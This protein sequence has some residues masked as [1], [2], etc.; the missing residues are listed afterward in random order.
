MI[1]LEVDGRPVEVPENSTVMDAANR[2]GIY[3]PHFCYHRKLSIAANC[4]MCLVQVEKAP[5]PLPACATPVTEGMKVWTHSEL[6]VQA[7]KGV[8]ELLLI[9]HPLDCPICDQGGECQLQDLAVGYGPSASR[10]REP[11]RVVANKELGPLVSA[12]EMT[13]CIHCTR[14]VRFGQEIA[15]IMELG[16]A[17]RGEHAEIMAFVGR[18]VDSELSGNMIDVCPVGAL[19]SRPFRYSARTWELAR[20]R[21]VAPHDSLGSNLVVQVMQDRVM[22]VLPLENEALNECWLSDRDRFSY[23]GLNSPQRLGAPMIKREGAWQE[24]DWPT[25]LEH[26]ATEL[27]RLRDTHGGESI[28]ALATPQST[29]EELYLLGRLTRGLGSGNVDFRLRQLDFSAD[30]TLTGTPWLGMPVGELSGLDRVLVVGSVLRKEQPLL[31][32]RIRQAVKKGAQLAIVNPVD[33][34]LLM[35]LHAK[36]IV[37]PSA[38]PGVMAQ[39][40]LAAARLKGRNV[41][42]PL[43]ALEVGGEAQRIAQ[44]LAEGQRTGI[45][46]GNLA[47]HH[48]A[49]AQLH[50]L[51]A[52]LAGIVEGRF[53]FLG[54]GANSVGGYLA[55]A[56]PGT[57]PGALNSQQMLERPRKGYVLLN[58]EIELDSA[59]PRLARAAMSAAECVVALCAYKHRAL[60]YAQVLLPVAPFTETAGSYVNTEGRLQRFEAVVRPQAQ[61][62]P[63]WKVLR[64]LGGLLGVKGFGYETI[65]EVRAELSAAIGDLP[66]RLD[67]GV[68]A[69]PVAP[70]A[71]SAGLERVGEVP[72]YQVD[73]IVRRAPALQRTRDAQVTVAWL[74]GSLIEQLGLGPSDRVR[75]GQE[76]G[77]SIVAYAR[78]DRLPPNCVR[79]PMACQETAGLG[80]PFGPVSVERVAVQA[81]VSA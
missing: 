25:A 3:V 44:S 64:V 60:E 16:M 70:P 47:A 19:T 51:A 58:A 72:I 74:H 35:R 53:G 20:R 10:Y 4:R 76:G 27:R 9:N 17:G 40:V 62:R 54:E 33:D 37:A 6:A 77:E 45:F 75:V 50:A 31:A 46:L 28:G 52:L 65:D 66:R 42:A 48:P 81:R 26:A 63:A 34:D 73:G 1:H 59:N 18:T 43:A 57:A 5:K 12:E 23:E 14:C 68:S 24:V 55:Q 38:M 36:C 8:M 61:A 49:R 71:P 67:N 29:L 15:G 79:L 30:G 41:P 69:P 32:H 7:Q 21:S 78:D 39:I 22:R 11:K 13:R 80:Q 56:W 2:L